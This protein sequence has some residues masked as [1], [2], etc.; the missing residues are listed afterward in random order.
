MLYLPFERDWKMS[1]QIMIDLP[2]C[3]G[4]GICELACSLYHEKECNPEKSRCRVI[5]YEHEGIL[6]SI[7]IMCQQCEESPCQIVCPTKA[8]NRNQITNAVTVDERRCIGC[9]YCF[10]VCPFGCITIDQKM[11]KAVKCNTCEGEPK[12]VEL[13]PTGALT[14]VKSD[15]VSITR[16]RSIFDK[17]VENLKKL[18][19][20][21]IE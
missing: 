18:S 16:K 5:R 4:C 12:C 7:P 15:K 20:S 8:I 3:T 19:T 13:C 10:T 11:G 1:F 2:K 17:Y 14:F 9:K 6:Y 21:M